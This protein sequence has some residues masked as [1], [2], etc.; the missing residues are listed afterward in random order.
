[1]TV[2]KQPGLGV[3]VWWQC[4]DRPVK[5][6]G[7]PPLRKHM[8]WTFLSDLARGGMSV[9]PWISPPNRFIAGKEVQNNRH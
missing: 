3:P 1:V 5:M 2:R 9:L 7:A 8:L 4:P 6:A